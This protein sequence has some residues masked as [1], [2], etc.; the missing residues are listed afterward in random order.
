MV[1]FR[2]YYSVLGVTKGASQDEIQKAYRKL[3]R[4]YHPDVNK[5][6]NAEDKFKELNEAY[7]VLKDPESRR[8]YDQV[9]QGF[10]HGQDFRPPPGWQGVEFNFD[11][12]GGTGGGGFG[13]TGFSDFFDVIFGG[14]A[15]GGPGRGR[16]HRN[17][18]FWDEQPVGPTPGK[19][20]EAELVI[21]LEEA[22]HCA[23]R[24]ISLERKEIGA[25]GGQRTTS[26]TYQVK[27]P[28]GTT[29]GMKIRLKG[30]GG[31]GIG[32]GPQG[33]LMLKVKF[34]PHPH[35]KVDGHNV[36][37]VLPITPWEAALG[38]K[39][40]VPTLD[41]QVVLK[42]PALS[43][44]GTQLRLKGKG[45]PRKDRSHGDLK[46]E[47]KIVLPS[48]LSPEEKELFEA[49]AEKSEFNPRD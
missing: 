13:G 41:G 26:R 22:F 11:R 25:D 48:E 1:Q 2:D 46:V 28:P 5:D 44:S 31:K 29:E 45:L 34:A 4:K 43:A 35:F 19:T 40:E 9:G 18:Q 15:G 23:S 39:L 49:L 30:E 10:A 38:T 7:E 16:P 47:L 42:I 33:D 24:S 14:R 27:I 12:M 8:R 17:T 36:I 6:Q 37:K 3:A 20:H 32:G 21:T